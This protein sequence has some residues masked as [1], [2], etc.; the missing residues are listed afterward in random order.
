MNASSKQAGACTRHSAE[1]M[2]MHI[3]HVDELYFIN[4]T[5]ELVHWVFGVGPRDTSILKNPQIFFQNL[6]GSREM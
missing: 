5:I 2:V 3:V 6:T 1:I 4:T